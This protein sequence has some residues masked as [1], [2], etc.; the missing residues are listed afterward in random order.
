M[1][2]IPAALD[3][4]LQGDAWTLATLWVITREDATVLRFTDHDRDL[5]VGSD[6]YK[7]AIGY[8]PSA[9]AHGVDGSSDNAEMQ[10]IL[11]DLGVTAE[12]M[13]AGLYDHAS[14]L[15]SVVNW[16]DTAQGT[17][18]LLKGYLGELITAAPMF[19]AELRGLAQLLR[20]NIGELYLPSCAADLFDTRCGV[21]PASW[22]AAGSPTTLTSRV[23]FTD[24][25]RSE[26]DDYWN[27]GILTWASGD[28]NGLAMDVKSST[29]T[30]VIVLYEPMPFDIALTDTYSI[31][32]G[33]AK[34][35]AEC[36]DRYDN[37][38]NHRGFPHIQGMADLL[39]GPQ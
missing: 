13:A 4:H 33:C 27:R 20:N 25:S 31:K 7:A 12:A 32:T 36:R 5:I 18:P 19:T 16:A 21:N 35:K 22:T 6:T 26:A 8:A 29:A 17:V 11:D 23:Q 2:S 24:T 15:V 3:A 28:N 9:F 30:G 37:L 34:T 1:K 39:R 38:I 10:A 14:V